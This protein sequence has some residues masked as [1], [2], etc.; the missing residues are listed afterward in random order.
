MLKTLY[1]VNELNSIDHKDFKKLGLHVIH[2]SITTLSDFIALRDYLNSDHSVIRHLGIRLQD[3]EN[4]FID[5]I[6]GCEKF[7]TSLAND[8]QLTAL[9][10]EK[11]PNDLPLG[12]AEANDLKD[13]HTALSYF[14]QKNKTL[15]MLQIADITLCEIFQKYFYESALLHPQLVVLNL[16]TH[17]NYFENAQ[18]PKQMMKKIDAIKQAF[19]STNDST[20]K[21]E[22]CVL[23]TQ[24]W[25]HQI[26]EVGQVYMKSAI[27][28]FNQ[29]NQ[30]QLESISSSFTIVEKLKE[31]IALPIEAIDDEIE[32]LISHPPLLNGRNSSDQMSTSTSSIK[33]A[34][35]DETMDPEIQD[36]LREFEI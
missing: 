11:L 10:I 26:K 36:I 17:L 33:T 7:I 25:N 19:A 2:V 22:L 3:W 1:K 18:L 6:I 24:A 34:S 12:Y 16:K 9:I 4:S 35:T 27:E 29:Q 32:V 28:Y 13:L 23:M 8:K 15:C 14:F 20:H 21:Y 30:I 5:L 31:E